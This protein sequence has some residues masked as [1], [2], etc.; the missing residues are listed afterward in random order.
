MGLLIITDMKQNNIVSQTYQEFLNSFGEETQTQLER[1][2]LESSLLFSLQRT[3][4]IS[5]QRDQIFLKTIFSVIIS[6]DKSW[7]DDAIRENLQEQYKKEFDIQEIKEAVKKLLKAGW[8]E[9]EGDG[10][11]PKPKAAEKMRKG[12]GEVADGMNSLIEFL[13]GETANQ[14]KK[15]FSPQ[16]KQQVSSNIISALNLYF[17]MYGIDFVN[18]TED[19]DSYH[20]FEDGDII[21][22]AKKGLE[23]VVGEALV[24]SLAS[25]ID[26]P[27]KEQ[28]HILMLWVKAYVGA[29]IMTLDPQLSSVQK[30]KLVGKTFLLDT[31]IILY[32]ITDECKQSKDYKKLIRTLRSSQCNLII[33]DEVV[34]EVLYHAESAEKNYRNNQVLYDSLDRTAIEGTVPNIFVKEYCLLKLKKNYHRTIKEFMRNYLEEG[35]ERRFIIDVIQ[36]KLKLKAGMAEGL[37]IDLQIQDKFES[38]KAEI[39]RLSRINSIKEEEVDERL[40]ATDARLYMAVLS[41][42]KDIPDNISTKEMLYADSYLVTYTEKGIK[43]AKNLRIYRNFVTRPALLINLLSDMGIFEEG[44]MDFVNL[45]D[46]PF[47]A[48]VIDENWTMIKTLSRTGVDMRYNSI[49][50]LKKD[51]EQVVHRYI[52]NDAEKEHISTSRDFS[53]LY[54]E[55]ISDYRQYAKDLKSIG[56]DLMPEAKKIV[57]DLEAKD[58]IIEEQGKIIEKQKK[59]IKKREGGRLHYGNRNEGKKEKRNL[60]N[61]RKR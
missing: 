57:S 22:K 11:V 53:K 55:E 21:E 4:G 5:D 44:A 56:Y 47:L 48:H 23:E 60:A 52:T 51:L 41:M 34:T 19:S 38:L 20:S 39:Y 61:K 16:Q 15:F 10:V 14:A 54:F 43:A 7:S 24:S 3:K 42:N 17:R 1:S 31:D 26:C 30:S 29:Q 59:I 8:L 33:P 40:A 27:T 49:T 9:R 13:I 50:R 45:F 18:M 58:M 12:I 36:E 6:V 32:G 37:N 46:N 25:L 2:F 28:A 35:E